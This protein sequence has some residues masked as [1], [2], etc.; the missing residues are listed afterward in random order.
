LLYMITVK[1]DLY[2]RYGTRRRAYLAVKPEE[3]KQQQVEAHNNSEA[4]TAAGMLNVK[5]QQVEAHNNSEAI[6][7]AGRRQRQVNTGSN[8]LLSNLRSRYAFM[9]LLI[10]GCV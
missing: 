10:P 9:R 8:I 3:V 4:I 2:D 7:A 5:Q 1:P 6:T